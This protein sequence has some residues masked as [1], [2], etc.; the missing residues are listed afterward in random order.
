MLVAWSVGLLHFNCGYGIGVTSPM[1]AQLTGSYLDQASAP[2]FASSLVLGQILGT[3]LGG[4]LANKLGRKQTCAA[5]ALGSALSWAALA[6]S[7][8]LVTVVAARAVTGCCDCLSLVAGYMYISE[9]AETRLRGS[10]LNSAVV[11]GGLGTAAAYMCGSSLVWRYSCCA[12]VA[13]N[14]LSLA[15]ICCCPQSPVFLLMTNKVFTNPKML[16]INFMSI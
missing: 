3:L 1:I 10:F 9:V 16:I 8:S 7:S 2:W 5:A 11:L 15:A 12:P 14:L 4:G 6:A 13:A